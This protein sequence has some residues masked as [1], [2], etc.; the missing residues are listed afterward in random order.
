MLHHWG[1]QTNLKRERARQHNRLG[2][3]DMADNWEDSL[4][5]ANPAFFSTFQKHGANA[6]KIHADAQEIVGLYIDMRRKQD[7]RRLT[8]EGGPPCRWR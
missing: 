2:D 7:F 5:Q 1:R 3:S 8:D 4:M 6:A